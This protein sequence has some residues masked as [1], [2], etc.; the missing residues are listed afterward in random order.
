MKK[1]KILRVRIR[2]N[3]VCFMPLGEE[4]MMGFLAQLNQ[5]P[6]FRVVGG[7]LYDTHICVLLW[8]AVLC[9]IL[10]ESCGILIVN[11]KRTPFF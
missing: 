2:F 4:Q 7:S 5:W 1:R 6:I 11:T 3:N 8:W 9:P 10:D